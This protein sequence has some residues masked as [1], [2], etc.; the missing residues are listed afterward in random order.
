MFAAGMIDLHGAATGVIAAEGVVAAD[1]KKLESA[2]QDAFKAMGDTVKKAQDVASNALEEVRKEGTIHKETNAKLAEVG[3]A[4]TDATN[5]LADMEKLFNKTLG[6]GHAGRSR[7][8]A[9]AEGLA[10]ARR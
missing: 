2:M 10:Q 8:R 9:R 6:R 1:L 4:A 3:K 7:R 5:K